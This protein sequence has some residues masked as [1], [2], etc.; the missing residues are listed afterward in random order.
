MTLGFLFNFSS[1]KGIGDSTRIK[2]GK[3]LTTFWLFISWYMLISKFPQY[4]CATPI[5]VTEVLCLVTCVQPL[6][7]PFSKINDFYGTSIVLLLR[8]SKSLQY[9]CKS[10]KQKCDLLL[11]Y[12]LF[13]KVTIESAGKRCDVLH[14]K[15]HT[16]AQNCFVTFQ[17][18]SIGCT[19]LISHECNL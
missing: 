10:T 11:I 18:C 8:I 9:V 7:H 14:Y 3:S 4:A 5:L 17:T 2:W 13:T 12:H 19:G 1:S 15:G 6:N 16:H